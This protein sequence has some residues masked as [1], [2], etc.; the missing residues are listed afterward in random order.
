MKSDILQNVILWDWLTISCKDEDPEV[1]MQLLGME[2]APWELLDHG[3]N[4]Y[5]QAYFFG[6]ISIWFDGQPGMGCCVNMSGQGCRSFEQYGSGDYNSLF[7]IVLGDP[8]RFNITRIDIAF[9]D[10]IGILDI[11]QIADDTVDREFVSRFRTERIEKEFKDGRPGLTVYHG[12]KKSDVMIR[13]YDKAAERGLPC[14]QHWIRVEMQLRKDRAE[15]FAR[16]SLDMDI[17]VLFRGVLLNYVRYTDDPG[18]DSN[19]SR[20]PLKK[21]WEQLVD[22]VERIRLFVKPGIEYNVSQLDHFVFDQAAGA[23]HCAVKLYGASYVVQRV[24]EKDISENK[25][26]SSLLKEFKFGQKK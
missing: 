11:D 20:W 13:I 25:K 4:G 24:L 6:S 3:A 7:G 5:R 18:N 19:P 14:S 23:L 16:Q 9:D 8:A 21:Y 2:S 15:E 1:W 26:Y 17:G 22:A 10:H 12:S